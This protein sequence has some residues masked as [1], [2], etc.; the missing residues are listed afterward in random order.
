MRKTIKQY[1]TLLL[2]GWL[3]MP[4]RADWRTHFAYTNVRQ[5]AL[6][7]DVVYGLSDGALFSVDRMTE[8]MVEWTK[9]TSLHGSQT[10]IALPEVSAGVY[11]L[12]LASDRNGM[13]T[14]KIILE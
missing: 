4:V 11:V 6:A 2:I 10:N 8:R 1:V 5:I 7:G 9:Q 14:Q 13:K 12:R 3:A